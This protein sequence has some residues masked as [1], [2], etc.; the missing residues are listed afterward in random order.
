MALI[1]RWRSG[2]VLPL[3][4]ELE[5]DRGQLVSLVPVHDWP[6]LPDVYGLH[7][8]PTCPVFFPGDHCGVLEGYSVAGGGTVLSDSSRSVKVLMFLEPLMKWALCLANVCV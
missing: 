6:L 4:Q 2:V 7:D 1:T 3:R 5:V 8:F